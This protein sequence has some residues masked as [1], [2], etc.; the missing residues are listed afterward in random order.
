M[1]MTPALAQ[2]FNNQIKHEMYSAYLYLA[3]SAHFEAENFSGFAHWMRVQAEEELEHAMKFFDFLAERG[4]PVALQA[5]ETPPST[6]G[7]PLS[8]FEA[9]LEHEKFVT[10]RIE[11]LYNL[12]VQDKDFAAQSFLTWFINEQVEE[13]ANAEQNVAMLQLVG[14]NGSALFMADRTLGARKAD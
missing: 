14:N 13:E 3:M 8:I 7:T 12:A 4:A 5:I 6:F 11:L 10:G 2:E 1:K 9:G